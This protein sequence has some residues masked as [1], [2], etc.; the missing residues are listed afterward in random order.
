MAPNSQPPSPALEVYPTDIPTGGNGRSP[1]PPLLT[2]SEVLSP[3][4]EDAYEP[5]LPPN[6]T[7]PAPPWNG[8][9]APPPGPWN[10]DGPPPPPPPGPGS[11]EEPPRPPTMSD[12]YPGGWTTAY[13]MPTGNEKTVSQIV[14]SGL[15]TM[16]KP[17]TAAVSISGGER[18]RPVFV[19]WLWLAF[20]VGLFV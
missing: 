16:S 12:V 19:S 1:P 8:D 15:S 17:S 5:Q 3:P 18:L 11:S 14:P 4:L 10:G 7:G 13:P 6:E 20:M 2:P 9:S